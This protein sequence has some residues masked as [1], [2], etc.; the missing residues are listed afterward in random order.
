MSDKVERWQARCRS[1][2]ATEY[3]K[4]EAQGK[5]TV[6]RLIPIMAER[7]LDGRIANLA[8]C[9][10]CGQKEGFDLVQRLGMSADI[11]APAGTET[12]P[13]DDGETSV[14]PDPPKKS[15]SRLKQLLGG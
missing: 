12:P 8:F 1:C 15:K 6:S 4:V 2:G 7:T 9:P 10:H 5:A 3:R 11:P 13:A 14:Q